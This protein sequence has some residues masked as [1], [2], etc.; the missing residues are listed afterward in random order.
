MT[1]CQ[2]FLEP[3]S[4]SEYVPELVTSLDEMLVGE[5]Y[6]GS[7]TSDGS[8]FSVL[9]A[10]DDDV[11]V[12]DI[13]TDYA[14]FEEDNMEKVRLAFTWDR[15]MQQEFSGYNV[16]GSIYEKIVGCNAALD[17]LDDVQ[18]TEE[19]KNWVECQALALRGYYYFHLVNLYGKPY[20]YDRNALGVPLKIDSRLSTSSL[21]RNTV[22]EVYDQVVEDLLEAE[23]LMQTLPETDWNRKDY[24][25]NLPFIQLLLS[26]VYLYMEDWTNALA[27][28]QKVVGNTN[29]SLSDLNTWDDPAVMGHPTSFTFDNPEVV[30][31]F[32]NQTDAISLSAMTI[33]GEGGNYAYVFKASTPLINSYDDNDLRKSQY[34]ITAPMDNYTLAVSKNVEADRDGYFS[35]DWQGG[36]WGIAFKVSEAYLNGA[37]AAVHLYEEGDASA[38]ATAYEYLD[39]LREKRFSTGTFE[40]TE[41]V[42]GTGELL[43]FVRAERRRELC[44][45]HHRWFDLRRYGMEPLAHEWKERGGQVVTYSLDKD[46]PKFTLLIPQEAMDENPALEQNEAWD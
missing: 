1:S 13:V 43:D 28:A 23:R 12:H 11:E 34:L 22:G 25:V 14:D 36:Y 15:L 35:V 7:Y 4:Q 3:K 16:Y 39:A 18:G 20:G 46:D 37:E 21:S 6:M 44:F 26:R 42:V 27:Y 29:F 45:E 38:L 31:L 10:F 5:S 9:G 2:E 17:Y 8:M 32:V 41:S 19:E 33:N 30:F 24:R 40:S